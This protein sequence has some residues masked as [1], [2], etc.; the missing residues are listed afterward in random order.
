MIIDIG[1]KFYPAISL[2]YNLQ[3]KV[4]DLE[5]LC[6]NFIAKFLRSFIYSATFQI[7]LVIFGIQIATMEDVHPKLS[8]T[9]SSSYPPTSPLPTPVNTHTHTHART[10]ARARTHTHTH[11]HTHAQH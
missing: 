7:I 10:H 9:M 4:T 6:K 1:P 8:S 3:V 5:I 2:P 11:T